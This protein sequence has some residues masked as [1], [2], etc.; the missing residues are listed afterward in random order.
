VRGRENEMKKEE[1]KKKENKKRKKR[2]GVGRELET[3]KE[4]K[5]HHFLEKLT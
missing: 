5:I 3:T 2:M 1:N 4:K